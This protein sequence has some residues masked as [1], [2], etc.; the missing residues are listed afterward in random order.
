MVYGGGKGFQNIVVTK[1]D[2]TAKDLKGAGAAQPIKEDIQDQIQ[3]LKQFPIK[4]SVQDFKAL[5][6]TPKEEANYEPPS[7]KKRTNIDDHFL[8]N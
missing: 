4:V 2:L 8:F 1:P 7:K 3:T 5:Q 6:R